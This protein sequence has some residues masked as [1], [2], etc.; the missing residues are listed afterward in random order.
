MRRARAG[1]NIGMRPMKAVLAAVVL[2]LAFAPAAR[3]PAP[4]RPGTVVDAIAMDGSRVAYATQVAHLCEQV[5]IWNVVTGKRVRSSTACH[6]DSHLQAFAANRSSAAWISS[7]C[8]NSECDEDLFVSSP[9]RPDRRLATTMCRGEVSAGDCKAGDWMDGLVGAGSVLAVS[10]WAQDEAGAV[11][12]AGLDVVVGT[13]LR[14]IVSGPN[15]LVAV[16][17]DAGRIAVLHD[18]GSVAVYTSRGRLLRTLARASAGDVALRGDW[19]LTLTNFST[20][21]AYSVATGKRIHRWPVEDRVTSLD[22]YGGIAVYTGSTN[23]GGSFRVHALRLKTGKDAIV[24]RG[25]FFTPLTAAQID[26]PGLV[27]LS[28]PRT[29]AFVPFAQVAA[30]VGLG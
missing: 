17:A 18:D 22:A 9:G 10:R 24:A 26:A 5:W 30:A 8:G 29:P 15:A 12:K 1:T 25:A 11:S 20:L 13:S 21:D 28:G 7:M 4:P 2:A 27:Y 19:L 14:R 3:A 16:A 23:W 6:F